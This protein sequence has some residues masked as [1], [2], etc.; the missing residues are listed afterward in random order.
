MGHRSTYWRNASRPSSAATFG[1][2]ITPQRAAPPDHPRS[3]GGLS[4]ITH[5]A[6]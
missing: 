3:F 5:R 1:E 6:R 4:A 2:V